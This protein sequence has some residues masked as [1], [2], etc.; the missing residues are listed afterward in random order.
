MTEKFGLETEFPNLGQENREKGFSVERDEADVANVT[1][2]TA[3]AAAALR[4]EDAEL[5]QGITFAER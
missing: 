3:L 1:D 2:E 5:G 4:Q